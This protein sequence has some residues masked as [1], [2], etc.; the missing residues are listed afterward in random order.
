MDQPTMTDQPGTT[1]EIRALKR[2]Q[3]DLETRRRELLDQAVELEVEAMQIG[4]RI[5]DLEK[6]DGH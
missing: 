2:Q 1:D 4:W 3:A 5:Y 6:Q